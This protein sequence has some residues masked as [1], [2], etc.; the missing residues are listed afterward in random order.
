MI[1]GKPHIH[2]I[3][4]A[5]LD[6]VWQWRWMEGCGEAIATFRNAVEILNEHSDFIFNHNEAILYEWVRKYDPGLF[7]QIQKLVSN[8]RWFIAGGWYLQPDVNLPPTENIVRH[9][10][11]GKKFFR[12]HF[13]VEPKVAYNFDSFGHSSG[14]PRL[15]RDHGYEFYVHMRPDKEV[16]DLPASIYIWEGSD[17]T[18]I[19]AHRIDV[20]LYL[21]ERSNIRQHI[22]E[23][24]DLSLKLNR[25]VAVFWGLGNHGGGATREDLAIIEEMMREEKEVGII[26]STTDRFYESIGSVIAE[27]PVYKG[28]VQRIFTGT[29]TSMARLKRKAVQASSA[30]IQMEKFESHN[31]GGEDEKSIALRTEKADQIWKDILFNDFHDILT[32]SCTRIAEEDAMELYGRAMENIREVNMDLVSR[33]NLKSEILKA[34]IPVTI[35][36]STDGLS[37]F[38][39]ELECM[40][41]YR[42]FRDEE[43]V[44]VLS[45]RK[46]EVISSQEEQPDALLPIHRWRRKVVFMADKL[47]KGVNHFGL[48]PVPA[49]GGGA[50]PV[51]PLVDDFGIKFRVVKDSADSWGTNTWKWDESVGEFM[52]VAG[53]KRIIAQGDIRTIQESELILDRSNIILR[54]ISYAGWPITEYRIRINWHGEH[55]RLKLVIPIDMELDNCLCEIPGGKINRRADG[56]EHC[57]GTWMHLSREEA[58]AGGPISTINLKSGGINIVHNGL[59]GYDFVPGELRLSVL[60]SAAYCHWHEYQLPD[61]IKSV[62]SAISGAFPEHMDQGVH[63]IRLAIWRSGSESP[64]P[65]SISDWLNAPPLVY[66]HLPVGT[67]KA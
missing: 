33:I 19:P 55:K 6:P 12:E 46:G 29:Y 66:P 42:P 53:S 59:H 30:V 43:K 39:V 60:R 26:H 10:L 41:D 1:N 32:G 18:R 9:I 2:L 56:Q 31:P 51:L 62:G 54:Q 37:R 5:H 47:N 8:G 7:R 38:P 44:L 36:N 22:S 27:A 63:D 21:T 35:F 23:G 57:H 45:N 28:E 34:H 40:A 49:N 61:P 48:N 11:E 15:L 16:L 65:E 52:E 64:A 13:G 3:C 4:N 17:G 67:N 20:G 50:S 24:I 14:L 58:G 25:D